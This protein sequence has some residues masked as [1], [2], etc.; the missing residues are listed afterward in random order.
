MESPKIFHL[1]EEQI[2][3]LSKIA[4]LNGKLDRSPEVNEQECTGW[5]S[6][7]DFVVRL[8]ERITENKG[9]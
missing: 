7:W 4:F 2:R 5:V 3:T 1:D 6:T 9:V 8:R